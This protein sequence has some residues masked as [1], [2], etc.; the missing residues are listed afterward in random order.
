MSKGF[1]YEEAK[2]SKR[3]GST[4]R[5][6]TQHLQLNKQVSESTNKDEEEKLQTTEI[7]LDATKV[8]KAEH[9]EAHFFL[10][11]CT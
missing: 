8:L 6:L 2:T 9:T 5:N 3:R 10:V 7:H 4:N 11:S 1:C